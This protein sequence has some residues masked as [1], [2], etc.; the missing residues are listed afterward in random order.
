MYHFRF[1]LKY[2]SEIGLFLILK[3]LRAL[4]L[5]NTMKYKRI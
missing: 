5:K 1:I 2:A 3:Q 4:T